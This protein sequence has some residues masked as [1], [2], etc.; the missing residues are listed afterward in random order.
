MYEIVLIDSPLGQ[1][2]QRTE[3]K[4]FDEFSMEYI[5]SNLHKNYL[6]HFYDFCRDLGGETWVLRPLAAS[7]TTP[8]CQLNQLKLQNPLTKAHHSTSSPAK[9]SVP[10]KCST[11]EKDAETRCTSSPHCTYEAHLRIVDP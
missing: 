7:A 11:P 10:T 4:D 5:R 6:E 9:S 8:T 1:F 2:F 3:K